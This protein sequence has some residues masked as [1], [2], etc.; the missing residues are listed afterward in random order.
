MLLK[1]VGP[2]L[3]RLHRFIDLAARG[4]AFGLEAKHSVDQQRRIAEVVGPPDPFSTEGAYQS[5]IA[6]AT[7]LEEFAREQQVAHFSYL[8]ELGLVKL[9]SIL[10]STIDDLAFRRLSDP[11]T[12]VHELLMSFAKSR[13]L[14]RPLHRTRRRTLLC[15]G[16]DTLSPAGPPRGHV[17][18][19]LRSRS[20][21]PKT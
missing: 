2:E 3:R 15:S 6:R 5:A 7:E 13:R 14:T 8:H 18:T 12:H 21:G 17:F 9:W 4:I 19:A 16:C 11:T 1:Q 10:E 20:N